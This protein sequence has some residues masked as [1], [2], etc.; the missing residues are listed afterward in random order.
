MAMVGMTIGLLF[1]A[2]I[3]LGGPIG[4]S[5]IFWLAALF[6][7][8]GIGVVYAKLPSTA[9]AISQV[10]LAWWRTDARSS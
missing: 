5:G 2:A 7:V 4:V 1:A 9:R 6:S 8:L 10:A 3:V